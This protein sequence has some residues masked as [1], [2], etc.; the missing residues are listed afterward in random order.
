MKN[1]SPCLDTLPFVASCNDRI[2][3]V[4]G[5]GVFMEKPKLIKLTD[6]RA[7]TPTRHWDILLKIAIGQ[8]ILKIHRTKISYN[9]I[10]PVDIEA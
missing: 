8:I 2:A 4:S 9:P 6:F 10:T 1:Q 7:A 5:R 3:F